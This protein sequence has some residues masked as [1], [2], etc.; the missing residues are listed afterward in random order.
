M[1]CSTIRFR[2]V[3]VLLKDIV[4]LSLLFRNPALV[5]PPGPQTPNPLIELREKD[6]NL[7]PLGYEP[8]EHSQT[9]PPRFIGY[10]YIDSRSSKK[11]H[12][13]FEISSAVS[14]PVVRVRNPTR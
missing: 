2:S 3:V 11:V 9:A 7:R 10:D 5:S 4:T 12:T 13:F 6:L 8:S 1:V 14:C